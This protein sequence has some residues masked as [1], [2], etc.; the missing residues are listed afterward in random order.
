MPV[1]TEEE[2]WDGAQTW[3]MVSFN[4]YTYMYIYLHSKANMTRC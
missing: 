2:E 1:E 4:I 3:S